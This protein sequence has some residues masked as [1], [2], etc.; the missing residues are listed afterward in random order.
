MIGTQPPYRLFHYGLYSIRGSTTSRTHLPWNWQ[1]VAETGVQFESRARQFP[2]HDPHPTTKCRSQQRES[3]EHEVSRTVCPFSNDTQNTRQSAKSH[4]GVNEKCF[5]HVC[6]KLVVD[7][8]ER[9]FS[10]QARPK[11]CMKE[12][13]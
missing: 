9:C 7:I 5:H 2:M 3:M 10:K 8:S 6:R 12:S 13:G 4:P 1:R 11:L